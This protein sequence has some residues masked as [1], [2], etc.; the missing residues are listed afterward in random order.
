MLIQFKTDEELDKAIRYFQ[1]K[2]IM[3]GASIARYAIHELFRQQAPKAF[4]KPTE[5]DARQEGRRICQLLGGVIPDR[6]V[7]S[8]DFKIYEV[9]FSGNVIEEAERTLP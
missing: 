9:S 4:F 3:T 6:A 7:N 1:S 5:A 8:C 2:G